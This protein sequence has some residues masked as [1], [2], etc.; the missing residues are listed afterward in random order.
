MSKILRKIGTCIG[1]FVLVFF[2]IFFLTISFF[3][4]P[5]KKW[6]KK[7]KYSILYFST[8]ALTNMRYPA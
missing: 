8:K 4:F 1:H 7:L 6:V 5:M 3:L 2:Y